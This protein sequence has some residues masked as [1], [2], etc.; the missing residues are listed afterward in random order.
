MDLSGKFPFSSMLRSNL[1]GC[2][3]PNAVSKDEFPQRGD[4]K[5]YSQLQDYDDFRGCDLCTDGQLEEIANRI[6][7]NFYKPTWQA[8]KHHLLTPE[9]P[10][11]AD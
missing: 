4:V 5:L 9:I 3:E 7:A 1:G 11:K 8:L 2:K 10:Q 6:F